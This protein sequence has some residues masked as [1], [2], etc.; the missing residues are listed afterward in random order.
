MVVV[1]VARRIAEMVLAKCL[2]PPS[3]RS[4]R[5][6]DVITTWFSPS[7]ATRRQPRDLAGFFGD[8][9]AGGRPV[10]DVAEGAGPRAGVAHDHHGGVLLG[11]ALTDVGAACFLTHGDKFV[12]FDDLA[13]LGIHRR[14]RH[15]HSDPLGLTQQCVV[16]TVGLFGM[17]R[18][19]RLDG[20]FVSGR[21]VILAVDSDHGGSRYSA[22]AYRQ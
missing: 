20:G 1:G 9:A 3:G 6:T 7:L 16:R 15:L 19:R 8:P 11:P 21:V 13:R 12:G 4:S 10:L 18:A 22:W 14:A 2:A 17:A 5:S